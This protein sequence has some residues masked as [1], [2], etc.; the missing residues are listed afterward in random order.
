[1]NL[2][3][4]L[5]NAAFSVVSFSAIVPFLKILFESQKQQAAGEDVALGNDLLDRLTERGGQRAN[6]L[7]SSGE[8]TMGKIEF[9]PLSLAAVLFSRPGLHPG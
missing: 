2:F 7:P 8:K 6:P 1:L 9:G 3:F 4:N 5:L